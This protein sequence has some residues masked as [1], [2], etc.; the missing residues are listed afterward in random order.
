MKVLSS[1]RYFYIIIIGS[2]THIIHSFLKADYSVPS[3][4]LAYFNQII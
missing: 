1:E 4:F 2:L 3:Q